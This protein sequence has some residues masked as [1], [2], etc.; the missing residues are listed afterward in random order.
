MRFIKKSFSK[1]TVQLLFFS[2]CFFINGMIY[3]QK[4]NEENQ[5]VDK[6]YVQQDLRDIIRESKPQKKEKRKSMLLVLPNVSSNPANGLLLG[7][8]GTA[9]FYLGPKELTRVSSIGFNAAYTTKNQLVTFAKSNM[10]LKEDKI[11][12]QGDWRFFIYNAPTWGLGTNA[13]DASG[14]NNR[15]MGQDAKIFDVNDGYKMG[16]HYLKF[17]EILNFEI[18]KYK[19]IGFGYHLDYYN[20]IKDFSL[21][22]DSIPNLLT[23]HYLYSELYDFETS[24]YL[25]SGLSLNLVYDSR[26]NLINA[27]KGYFIN[28]NYRYNPK[29]L[30]S[31]QNSSSLWMEFRTYV[32]LSKEVPR[33]LIAFWWVGSFQ[34]TG[35]QP[36]LTLMALGEDQR[37]RSGRGYT[38][39]RFRGEDLIYGEVEYRFPISPNSKILGGVL[40]LNAT[41]TSNRSQNVGLFDYIRPGAGVGLRFMLN[42]D[43][44]TNINLDFAF[45]TKS[46]GLYFSGTET[47]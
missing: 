11:F 27:Y 10:Y 33:H 19:Y 14:L 8:A 1:L 13:P 12:L 31:N 21:Q 22:L 29:F 40:F 4:G 5:Q 28:V 16:Y 20:K 44:R 26:D 36:Y 9:G 37:A 38:A 30:G 6:E 39:G 23:P 42:K 3:G 46:K 43:F 47:F 7:I 17:H 32:P 41:S 34:I 18:G 24:N 2:H 35:H 15:P 45:G 25:L